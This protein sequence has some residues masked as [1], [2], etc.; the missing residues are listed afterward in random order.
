MELGSAIGEDQ[1]KEVKEEKK[2]ELRRVDFI[3]LSNVRDL[4]KMV[5]SQATFGVRRPTSTT[6]VDIFK[7]YNAVV[8]TKSKFQEEA[9]QKRRRPR[10]SAGTDTGVSG[11]NA[12]RV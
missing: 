12:G 1:V 8:Y 6:S 10:G 7:G 5:I 9:G 2:E 3:K 4:T 11:Y